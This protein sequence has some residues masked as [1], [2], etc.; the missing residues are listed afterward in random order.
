VCGI[1]AVL[2]PSARPGVI[3]ALA[4][5]HRPILHRGPDGEGLV[6]LTPEGEAR[7]F[8]T[9]DSAPVEAPSVA[10]LAFRRL[11]ILDVSDAAAQPMASA[12][13]RVW[14]VFNGEIY[15]FA[16]L[17]NELKAAGAVFRSTGDTEVV[18]AAYQRWGTGCFE[19][20]DGMWAIV[21]LD[22][23]KRK[24]V[25]SRDRF[26][27]KP[28]YWCV[29]DGRL[30]LASEVKQILTA[31]KEQPR[32][33][34]SLVAKYL[35]GARLPNL[36][37]TF[38][39]GINATP[40]GHWFEAALDAP[41]APPSFR[42]YWQLPSRLAGENRN[43]REGVDQL[44]TALRRAAATHSVSDVPLGC[45]LSGG[46]DSSI[47]TVLAAEHRRAAGL[48]TPT[49][50]FGFRDQFDDVSELRYSDA[51]ARA[52]ALQNFEIGFDAAWIERN[53]DRVVR[54]ME[55][56]PLAMA[57]L[58]QYR[59]FELCRHHGVTVVL[60][61]QGADEIFGGYPYHERLFV[62]D[63]VRRR[64]WGE[65]F[66]ELGAV[67][68][69][70]HRTRAAVALECLAPWVKARFRKSV[71]SHPW[72]ADI[73][74]STKELEAYADRGG[75]PS[76]FYRQIYWDIKWGNVRLILDFADKNSM[77]W[78]IEARVPYFDR[79]VVELAMSMPDT[80]KV[81]EGQ[82]KRVLRD[83]GRRI[84]PSEVT[85]RRTRMGFGTPAE[86][87][88]RT[89]LWPVMRQEITD[90]SFL[91]LPVFKSAGVKQQIADFE[92]RRNNDY[93]AMWRLWALARWRSVHAA[94]A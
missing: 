54:S 28:L 41:P 77:S 83:V 5:L 85:E 36:Y 18:L 49:F 22:F 53:I 3:R 38:F 64:L 67:A 15:N 10:G 27:I 76:A 71:V 61:G 37:E 40:A 42:A 39:D 6:L 1:S 89:Q 66:R 79:Q 93:D 11:K 24:V 30:L 23:E 78:S 62:L 86:T 90:P 52:S 21:I 72:L 31:T 9:F 13:G 87:F 19:R 81:S 94:T 51:V 25:A 46:L 80:F 63:R 34:L 69:R 32:A 91:S 50:S 55:E 29:A 17:R 35:Q 45:L 47:T 26:G 59:V 43:Y 84:L 92:S 65:A 73:S 4:A 88:I 75:D 70:D 68:S 58:A 16:D 48:P 20:L 82:R 44:H 2:D 7:R 74:V 12:D 57:A 8:P 14:L 60:D 33:N 56:P